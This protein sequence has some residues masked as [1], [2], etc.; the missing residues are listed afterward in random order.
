[1]KRPTRLVG[2]TVSGLYYGLCA[3]LLFLSMSLL[4]AIVFLLVVAWLSI[5]RT[6]FL[7]VGRYTAGVWR[8]R[9][10][11][12]APII[13]L[14]WMLRGRD[15]EKAGLEF[16]MGGRSVAVFTLMSRREWAERKRSL[17]E[18]SAGGGP[19]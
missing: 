19:Q 10:P 12:P 1:M 5:D 3:A 14:G 8:C 13:G 6:R 18:R 16:T 9:S 2:W 11:R 4:A 15:Y 7:D 17:A